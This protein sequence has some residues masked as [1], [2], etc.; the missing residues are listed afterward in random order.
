MHYPFKIK[1]LWREMNWPFKRLLKEMHWLSLNI[2]LNWKAKGEICHPKNV[3]T[4]VNVDTVG[5]PDILGD[6][7]VDEVVCVW[8]HGSY[9]DQATGRQNVEP[10]DRTNYFQ[11]KYWS[12]TSPMHCTCT[13][14]HF[15]HSANLFVSPPHNSYWNGD[16]NHYSSGGWKSLEG[17][18]LK[19]LKI[20]RFKIYSYIINL[21][22]LVSTFLGPVHRLI[23]TIMSIVTGN[24]IVMGLIL[25]KEGYINTLFLN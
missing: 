20:L 25:S 17:L 4:G 24:F 13:S 2:T 3:L 15:M 21:P 1:Q 12:R 10:E 16:L 5:L 11:C 18:S 7:A 8:H 22:L 23:F 19:I 9:A 6:V 14:I